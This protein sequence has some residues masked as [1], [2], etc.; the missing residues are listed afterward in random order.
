MPTYSSG[1][2]TYQVINVSTG[3]CGTC[4]STL[5]PHPVFTR[6]NGDEVIQ[7]TSVTIGGVNGLNS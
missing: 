7:L 6:P 5:S 3:A 1:T 4:I 2:Y